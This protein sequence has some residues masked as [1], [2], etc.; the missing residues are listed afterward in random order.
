MKITFYQ[1]SSENNKVDKDLVY[2]VEMEG[3]LRMPTSLINPSID[4]QFSSGVI[5]INFDV[6]CTDDDVLADDSEIVTSFTENIINCNY[7]YIDEFERYY[8]VNDIIA[9][10]NQMFRFN[11]SID[12]LMSHKAK[13]RV[14]KGFI[15]RNEN[16]YNLK[17]NDV[18][19]NFKIDKQISLFED[20]K[21]TPYGQVN[22][23]LKTSNFNQ[24]ILFSYMT[25]D[26]IYYSNSLPSSVTN[27]LVTRD[28]VGSN[29]STQYLACSG[30]LVSDLIK[31]IFQDSQLVSFIKSC[32][33]YPF[34]IPNFTSGVETEI[35]I[36]NEDVVLTDDFCYPRQII[37]RMVIADFSFDIENPSFLDYSPHT[38]YELWLPYDKYVQINGEDLI[39]CRILVYYIVNYETGTA[40]AYI[41]NFTKRIILYSAPVTLG[42]DI[43]MN[44]SNAKQLQDQK[45][46]LGIKTSIGLIGSAL[47][48]AS[49]NPLG[50]VTG[51][52]TIG[53]AIS[54][55]NQMYQSA[56]V[57]CNSGSEGLTNWQDVH[58]KIT[59]NQVVGYDNEYFKF[60][61][62]PLNETRLISS[63][64]GFTQIEDIHLENFTA[65][66]LEKSLLIDYFKKGVIL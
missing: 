55:A 30:G 16:D 28:A 17:V 20:V 23:Q 45:I 63:L 32:R 26:G 65:T 15:S 19:T 35:K 52:K 37:D 10:S 62:R 56:N 47:T 27:K 48:I 4:V 43:A 36:G 38:I 29:M 13:F 66:T 64:S 53:D 39:N 9:I 5:N 60:K 50:F 57:S 14:L 2:I 58:I 41:Y 33:A 22:C 49:G 51:A 42:V 3:T 8:F 40:T 31:A 25:T 24:N 61:G 46:S 7:A 34:D 6:V 12:V 1:N 11:M 18:L 21:N 54:T 59:K 44:S